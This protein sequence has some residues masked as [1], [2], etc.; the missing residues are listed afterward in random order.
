MTFHADQQVLVTARSWANPRDGI[1]TKVGPAFVYVLV[2][3]L[4][5]PARFEVKTGRERLAASAHTGY[6][7]RVF[8]HEGYDEHIER[9][10]VTEKL[11]EKRSFLFHAP[12]WDEV[13]VADLTRL[14]D[15]LDEIAP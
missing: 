4:P 12:A 14:T 7:M 11:I 5:E 13:S 8:T 2:N 10:R 9:A 1:V 15:L 6:A 3:G